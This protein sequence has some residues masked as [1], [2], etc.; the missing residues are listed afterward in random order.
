MV[1]D[2]YQAAHDTVTGR[3]IRT[4]SAI[5]WLLKVVGERLRLQNGTALSATG[6][7]RAGWDIVGGSSTYQLAYDVLFTPAAGQ[8]AA[9]NWLPPSLAGDD[10]AAP[11]SA[12][13]PGRRA[14]GRWLCARGA[15]PK[16]ARRDRH[17]QD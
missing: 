10:R 1:D 3:Q 11:T 12:P 17:Q 14:S 4:C 15:A 13:P 7:R 9:A 8:P 5:S 6:M 16:S 2:P